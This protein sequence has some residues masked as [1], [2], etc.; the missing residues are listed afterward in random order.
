MSEPLLPPLR[1]DNAMLSVFKATG[2]WD[3][4]SSLALTQL[5]KSFQLPDIDGT[6]VDIDSIP[7]MWARPLLFQMAL[8]DDQHLLH[9]QTV[10]EWRGLLA[11]MVLRH[12]R[13]ISGVNVQ[14]LTLAD[15]DETRVVKALRA[16]CPTAPTLA[17]DTTW[18]SLYVIQLG[19][20]AI[21][22]TSPTT[23]VCTA[24]A[25]DRRIDGRVV[26]WFVNGRLRDPIEYLNQQE[27]SQLA[28]WLHVVRRALTED[29]RVA[30]TEKLG[31]AVLDATEKFRA[32]LASVAGGIVAQPDIQWSE[33]TLGLRVGVFRHLDRCV[34][35]ESEVPERSHV[36]LL[37]SDGKA[38]DI[39]LL[40]V[41]RDIATQWGC[42]LSE[43]QVIRGATLS[44]TPE[45]GELRDH[46]SFAGQ[47]LVLCEVC[48]LQELFTKRLSLI[49]GQQF[50]P[51]S[52]ASPGS[53]QLTMFGGP[54]TPL[55]PLEPKLLMHVSADDL[56]KG[57]TFEQRTENVI[58]VTLRLRLA[59]PG[60]VGKDVRVTKLYSAD[61][62]VDRIDNVPNLV[63]WPNFEVADGSWKT[64]YS[65]FR[66]TSG[67]YAYP[68]GSDETGAKSVLRKEGVIAREIRELTVFPEAMVCR[69]SRPNAH[70]DGLEEGPAGVI[71]LKQPVRV[72]R[73]TAKMN[74]GIDF[75]T[76]GTNVY[77]QQEGGVPQPLR[78]EN[79]QFEVTRVGAQR[80]FTYIDF[81]SHD[82]VVMPLLS[83][84]IELY[85]DG[86]E[87]RELRTVL[88]G[89]I[90]YILDIA[91]A[92]Q[93]RNLADV[94]A[95]AE[96]K[97]GGPDERLAAEAF[98]LEVGLQ[99]AAFAATQGAREVSWRFAFPT[100]FSVV[101]RES[102]EEIWNNLCEKTTKRTGIT[103]AEEKPL[104][105]TESVASA[106]FLANYPEVSQ[107]APFQRGVV[108]MD[109][110][111][112]TSDISVWQGGRDGL[113]FQTS[114]KYA[115][116]DIF[117]EAFLGVDGDFPVLRAFGMKP[118]EGMARVGAGNQ[119][120]VSFSGIDAY[121]MTPKGD[122]TDPDRT[123]SEHLF[124]MLPT[125]GVHSAVVMFV[126]RLGLAFA[127]L[128]YYTGL[129]LRSLAEQ[130]VYKPV[131]PDIYVVGRGSL[132][133]RWINHGSKDF[134]PDSMAAKL[135]KSVVQTA[136]G[137]DETPF[138]IL[139]T[140]RPK[141]EVAYGLVSD[142]FDFNFDPSTQGFIA[143]E[144]FRVAGARK[145][146]SWKDR[147]TAEDAALGLSIED[148]A[149]FRQFLDCFAESW[150]ET[151]LGEF[152][153]DNDAVR[154]VR[155]TVQSEL[156]FLQ[157]LDAQEVGVDPPFVR[158][159]RH[160]VRFHPWG[161]LD[162]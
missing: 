96:L 93:K 60:G 133:L 122:P 151:T 43:V 10:G 84:F 22:L 111:G 14:S 1:P 46:T 12:V 87:E 99:C 124:E 107:A 101:D 68:Y 64:Y 34:P 65:Y 89:H 128:M 44:V 150:G 156:S 120:R 131:M 137:F 125:H 49:V 135:L 149:N 2:V 85:Q 11:V 33:H 116:R 47:R 160:Y 3:R 56:A 108:C 144:D 18:Q 40:V 69:L 90:S 121:L 97:W 59:G 24:A 134:G 127:G 77:T 71:L 95:R 141:S 6:G 148:V 82:A 105:H 29:P 88:D 62:D 36:R 78:L 92:T 76:S 83:L 126:Q 100:Q 67:F 94:R 146:H 142:N 136:S 23:L 55:I 9:R 19:G 17:S 25:Y 48:G 70:G 118:P 66:S 159:L 114:P 73:R 42:P 61:T 57:V 54:V 7:S 129:I 153:T 123:T 50:L 63:I 162:A 161:K 16:T 147:L 119:D 21:G 80:V 140:P 102:F 130:G 143:G 79:L 81:L 5:A 104:Q 30:T 27:R 15:D 132:A 155:E 106:R 72:Q 45:S 145:Q 32:A 31:I 158:A 37:P 154:I 113:K 8:F 38:P 91:T 98:L 53:D 109:V 35:P 51:G 138:R 75:G 110:G 117:G 152:S 39:P 86:H 58:A 20:S 139:M 4:R 26:P 157:D 41:D 28:A 112:G 103:R 74:I 115:G 13:G 52:Q